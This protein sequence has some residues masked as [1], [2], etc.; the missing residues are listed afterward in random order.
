MA[1]TAIQSDIRKKFICKNVYHD[2]VAHVL[3]FQLS[4]RSSSFFCS[5]FLAVYGKPFYDSPYK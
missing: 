5:F 2:V 1:I 3:S 4:A